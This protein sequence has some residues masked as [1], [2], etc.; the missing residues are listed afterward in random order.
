MF[1]TIISKSIFLHNFAISQHHHNMLSTYQITK[2]RISKTI[3][4]FN[5]LFVIVIYKINLKTM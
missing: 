2:D 4:I 1:A 3:N 5:P